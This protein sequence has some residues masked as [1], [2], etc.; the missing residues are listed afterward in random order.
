MRA[1]IRFLFL[2]LLLCHFCL[3]EIS[4][5]KG[6]KSEFSE[7]KSSSQTTL[8]DSFDFYTDS[9]YTACTP[10]VKEQEKCG[11]CY[12]FAG[13]TTLAVRRCKVTGTFTDLSP[14]DIIACGYQTGGCEGGSSLDTLMYLEIFGTVSE[15]CMPYESGEGSPGE[16]NW[17]TRCT[18]GTD[19]TRYYCKQG[20]TTGVVE[21]D[22]MKLEIYENGPLLTFMTAY[23]DLFDYESG[24]YRTDGLNED[25]SG[26][27][28][29][30]IHGWGIQDGTDYWVV[31]NSWG[32]DWGI[33][34]HFWIDMDD[35]KSEA[36]SMGM[37]C[38]PE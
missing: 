27:H 36:G 12:A 8:P 20:S 31:Q 32:A 3:S 21:R 2:I 35:D 4:P 10:Q 22:R 30:V 28:A 11:G 13:T 6:S 37:F 26:G 25:E 1:K 14:E 15:A 19:N 33:N 17:S 7:I 24:V 29:V 34:G 38:I 16:C 23:P 5:K 9:D 18:A